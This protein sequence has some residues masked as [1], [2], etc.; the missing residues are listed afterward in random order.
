MSSPVLQ[1]NRTKTH[2]RGRRV[3]HWTQIRQQS[4]FLPDGSR[5]LYSQT[6]RPRDEAKRGT[7]GRGSNNT[8]QPQWG[9]LGSTSVGLSE[10]KEEGR[11][12]SR[13]RCTAL[14]LRSPSTLQLCAHKSLGKDEHRHTTFPI[15]ANGL[16]H[17]VLECMAM[18]R[19]TIT[20]E[21]DSM[22]WAMKLEKNKRA[23]VQMAPGIHFTTRECGLFSRL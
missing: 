22:Q 23:N 7:E 3:Q 4:G 13:M 17:N 16:S 9:C 6:H 1:I 11:I 8:L 10:L 19:P 5:I 15:F 18:C 14:M 2:R 12:F 21:L 20:Q